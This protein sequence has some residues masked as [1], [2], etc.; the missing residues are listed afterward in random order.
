[1]VDPNIIAIGSVVL[2]K[3]VAHGLGTI[4]GPLLASWKAA[5]EAKAH[6]ISAEADADARRITARGVADELRI[7]AEVRCEVLQDISIANQQTSGTVEIT[8]AGIAQRWEVHER[9]RLT[10]VRSVI[11]GAATYLRDKE[12]VDHEPDPDWTA[13]FFDDVQDVS[14]ADMQSIWARILA[15]EVETPGRTS[16]RTLSILRD[17]CQREAQLFDDLMEYRIA[18]FILGNCYEHITGEKV[19]DP[20]LDLIN[21]GLAVPSTV[22][23]TSIVLTSEVILLKEYRRHV[24][25]IEG[26]PGTEINLAL[27]GVIRLTPQGRELAGFCGHE[28]NIK[29]LSCFAEFLKSKMC[30]LKLA[31]IT[32]R[33]SDGAISVDPDSVQIVRPPSEN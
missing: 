33:G 13:R 19:I 24:L 32:S 9:K 27:Q 20:L 22:V 7:V 25:T 18:D 17:M 10:N 16:L 30:V 14:S 5:R 23:S 31:E 3:Y 8:P 1:M 26:P 15:G 6:L 12:V 21:I 11:G 4:V 2:A 28:P 29:Y